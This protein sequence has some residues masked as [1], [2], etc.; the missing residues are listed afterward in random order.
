MFLNVKLNVSLRLQ[1]F[2]SEGVFIIS[3]IA[4]FDGSH[5]LAKIFFEKTVYAAMKL[6]SPLLIKKNQV[7]AIFFAKSQRFKEILEIGRVPSALALSNVHREKVT[8]RMLHIMRVCVCVRVFAVSPL[9]H[10]IL[11]A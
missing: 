1:P 4:N 2:K 8:G 7:A 5:G 10:M 3:K 11:E 9:C 6:K